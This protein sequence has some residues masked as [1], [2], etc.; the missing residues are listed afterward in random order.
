MEVPIENIEK[1]MQL[2]LFTWQFMQIFLSLL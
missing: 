2:N 1:D